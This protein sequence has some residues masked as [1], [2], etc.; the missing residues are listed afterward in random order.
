MFLPHVFRTWLVF[1]FCFFLNCALTKFYM[2]QRQ[3]A[4]MCSIQSPKF[5]GSMTWCNIINLAPFKLLVLLTWAQ[6]FHI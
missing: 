6:C 4:S 1:F 5:W 3:N 2:L